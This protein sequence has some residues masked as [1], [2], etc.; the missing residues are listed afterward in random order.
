MMQPGW[1]ILDK[2]HVRSSNVRFTLDSSPTTRFPLFPRSRES[3]L[4]LDSNSSTNGQRVLIW[5]RSD[6][7]DTHLT[8][9][10]RMNLEQ[11]NSI[12]V[13]ISAGRNEITKC[14]LSIRAA[15]A[16]LR[17]HTA[18]AEIVDQKLKILG[19]SQ[20]GS[21][22]MNEILADTTVNI[23]IPYSVETD[24]REISVR[25][26]IDYT[27]PNGD[28]AFACSASL[29]I[30]L[31]LA[32]NVQDSFKQ[33][34]LVSKFTVGLSTPVPVRIS[35]CH[36]QGNRDFRVH[37]PASPK[38]ALDVFPRQPLSL[39]S[40]IYQTSA[41]RDRREAPQTKLFLK[42]EYCCLV[43]DIRAAVETV[44]LADLATTPLQKFSRPLRRS[45][46]AALHLLYARQDLEAIATRRVILVNPFEEWGWDV[47]LAGLPPKDGAELCTWLRGWYE[48][49]RIKLRQLIML[50]Y[51]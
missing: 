28:F 26:F 3:V 20:P 2:I 15:S 14:K 5:P 8:H 21:I 36:L 38:I 6:S 13:A 30:H 18:D 40:K 45:L 9:Y 1:Y 4:S 33:A 34:V 29:L 42:V 12:K 27:T 44:F 51:L 32:I 11:P 16:G 31:P 49:C 41:H 22:Y 39:V 43:E 50:S 23:K 46:P 35:S 10:E 24:P 37:A 17:L 48:V 19:R 7:L 25:A 47:V